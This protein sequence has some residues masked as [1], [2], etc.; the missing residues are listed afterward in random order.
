MY[1]RCSLFIDRDVD[2]L[3]RRMNII[4]DAKKRGGTED[5]RVVLLPMERCAWSKIKYHIKL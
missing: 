2:C 3:D 5:G 1:K 4:V